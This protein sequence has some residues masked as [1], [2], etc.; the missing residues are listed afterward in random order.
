M[1]MERPEH[2]DG[3]SVE[4]DQRDAREVAAEAPAR[5]RR[6]RKAR[7]PAEGIDV[8]DVHRELIARYP[9]VR[10]KLTE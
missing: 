2:R 7:P 10:A 9:K 6:P 5:A 4:P 1:V 8:A 3:S